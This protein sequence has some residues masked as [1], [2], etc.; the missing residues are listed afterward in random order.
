VSGS[1]KMVWHQWRELITTAITYPNMRKVYHQRTTARREDMHRQWEVTQVNATNKENSYFRNLSSSA[2]Y[3]CDP[4]RTKSWQLTRL[5]LGSLRL[6]ASYIRILQL[7]LLKLI[8]ASENKDPKWY[9]GDR[10]VLV[11][12]AINAL[13]TYRNSGNWQNHAVCDDV[14]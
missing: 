1:V 13:R 14:N 12:S 8:L 9:H 2:N 3:W 11:F 7:I 6:I 10:A 5:I 4:V